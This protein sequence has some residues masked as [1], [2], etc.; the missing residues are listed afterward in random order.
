[1]NRMY[2]TGNL[3]YDGQTAHVRRMDFFVDIAVVSQFQLMCRNCFDADVEID[4]VCFLEKT[5]CRSHF[6]IE[7]SFR[8]DTSA[9][10]G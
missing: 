7:P 2:I 3:G 10:T 4:D 9:A 5:L 6:S 1:M 8:F